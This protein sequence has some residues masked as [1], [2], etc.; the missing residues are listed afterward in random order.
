MQS[1][2]VQ[3]VDLTSADVQCCKT[4]VL[5]H[6]DF[7]PGELAAILQHG[8]AVLESYEV[9]YDIVVIRTTLS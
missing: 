2:L 7:C 8:F 1:G 6:I 9:D 5:L 3:F 4:Q